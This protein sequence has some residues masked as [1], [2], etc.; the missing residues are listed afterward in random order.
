MDPHVLYLYFKIW[1]LKKW[2]DLTLEGSFSSLPKPIF[3][4][5]IFCFGLL[6]LPTLYNPAQHTQTNRSRQK[7]SLLR[8]RPAKKKDFRISRLDEA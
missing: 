4:G 8:V 5:K 1:G 3:A 6:S 2:K 7:T